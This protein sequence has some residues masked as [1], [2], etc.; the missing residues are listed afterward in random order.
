MDGVQIGLL[1][2]V[3]P[4]VARNYGIDAEIYA[5]ELDFTALTTLVQPEKTYHPLPKYPAV[6]RDIAVV[7]DEAV[8]VGALTDCIRKA[9]G[10]LLRD[11]R[12]F[13]IYRGKGIDDGKK[14]VAFSLTLRADDRTLTD[15]DS[16]GAVSAVMT[17]LETAH[18]A[19]L[20]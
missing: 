1:G 3:H 12:L 8:T 16:D 10:K 2:Q 15:S 20:R 5:A 18:G 17:A 6:S 4:L 7:C 14:S 13:D 19:K 9:G 11:V